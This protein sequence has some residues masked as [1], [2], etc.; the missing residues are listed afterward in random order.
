MGIDHLHPLGWSS[1]LG[2]LL[3]LTTWNS[4]NQ[5]WR[6]HLQQRAPVVSLVINITIYLVGGWTTHL[7]NISQNGNLLQFSG[8]KQKKIET[9]TY[10]QGSIHRKWFFRISPSTVWQEWFLDD[11]RCENMACG[12]KSSSC[13]GRFPRCSWEVQKVESFLCFAPGGLRANRPCKQWWPLMGW[14]PIVMEW[15]GDP[16]NGRK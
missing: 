13:R 1:K 3:F 10:L 6:L 12:E 5:S 11:S 4:N 16:I 14:W 2:L 8:W 15:H 9:T 7:K